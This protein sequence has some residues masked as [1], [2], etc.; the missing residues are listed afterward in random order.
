MLPYLGPGLLGKKPVVLPGR[1]FDLSCENREQKDRLTIIW[2]SLERPLSLEEKCSYKL[3]FLVLG[4]V[5][6]VA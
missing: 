4:A 5:Y 1:S 2:Y 6:Y 3:I